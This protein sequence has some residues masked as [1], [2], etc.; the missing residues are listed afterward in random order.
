MAAATQL[1][2]EA[3]PRQAVPRSADRSRR[4]PRTRGQWAVVV[5]LLLA[6]LMFLLPVLVLFFLAQ[7]VFVEGIALTGVKG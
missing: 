5:V 4:L 1:P 6:T 7:K 3:V 2:P